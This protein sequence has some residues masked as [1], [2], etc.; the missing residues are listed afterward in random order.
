MEEL[1]HLDIVDFIESI[2]KFKEDVNDAD[3]SIEDDI[4]P[5]E[6]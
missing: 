4:L 5:L 2:L 1:D 3:E 6:F